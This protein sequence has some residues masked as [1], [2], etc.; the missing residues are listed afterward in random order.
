M[1]KYLLFTMCIVLSNDCIGQWTKVPSPE[2]GNT[3]WT[4][5]CS[6]FIPSPDVTTKSY[7][8]CVGESSIYNSTDLGKTWNVLYQDTSKVNP[9]QVNY[10]HGKIILSSEDSIYYYNEKIGY[11]SSDRMSQNLLFSSNRGKTWVSYKSP[12]FYKLAVLQNKN[13]IGI[14]KEGEVYKSNTGGKYWQTL[15]IVDSNSNTYTSDRSGSEKYLITSGKNCVI[16]FIRYWSIAEDNNRLSYFVSEDNGETFNKVRFRA[17]LSSSSDLSDSKKYYDYYEPILVE[18]GDNPYV[19]FIKHIKYYGNSDN[20]W[21]NNNYKDQEIYRFYTDSNSHAIMKINKDSINVL[22]FLNP[23]R[24]KY[25]IQ[26]RAG[27]NMIFSGGHY[28]TVSTDN[29]YGDGGLLRYTCIDTNSLPAPDMINNLYDNSF[30]QDSPKIFDPATRGK[31][32]KYYV[33]FNS[34]VSGLSSEI[35]KLRDNSVA[36]MKKRQEIFLGKVKTIK[37][38]SSGTIYSLI[39]DNIIF[40]TQKIEMV[41]DEKVKLK[42]IDAPI[43]DNTPSKYQGVKLIQGAEIIVDVIDLARSN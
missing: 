36:K 35:D 21:E 31:E 5:S 22:T 42:L 23:Y 15:N 6:Y 17:T 2:G 40:K 16:F 32:T 9:K 26:Y 3:S 29:S 27:I 20:I 7:I 4:R 19:W 34:Y 24:R 33:P 38:S 11:P 1:L 28:F 41:G 25:E 13:L 12:G 39:Y 43:R 10:Y 30:L 18:E 14:T 8:Y 37:S